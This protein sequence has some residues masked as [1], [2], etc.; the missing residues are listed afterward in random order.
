MSDVGRKTTTATPANLAPR[1]ASCRG[2]RNRG[3]GR[4]HGHGLFMATPSGES[5]CG[6]YLTLDVSVCLAG[7]AGLLGERGFGS[8]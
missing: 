6:E 7:L 2:V 4:G 8:Q 1:D 3:H 5:R